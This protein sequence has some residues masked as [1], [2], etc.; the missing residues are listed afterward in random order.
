M[1][2]NHD[3]EIQGPDQ[4]NPDPQNPDPQ[5]PEQSGR[6]ECAPFDEQLGSYLLADGDFPDS[7]STADGLEKHIAECAACREELA[8]LRRVAD[9]VSKVPPRVDGG[10]DADR[11]Q[12]LLQAASGGDSK[13]SES[14]TEHTRGGEVIR[15]IDK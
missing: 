13:T 1:T 14:T 15:L 3:S 8:L 11:R 4:Q 7:A 10:L 12:Q 9:L 5:D 6:P 2:N